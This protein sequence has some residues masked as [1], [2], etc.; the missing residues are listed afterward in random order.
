[1]KI[2]IRCDWGPGVGLGHVGR[3]IAIGE[4][5][6]AQGHEVT[7]F[8]GAGSPFPL[9]IST[10]VDVHVLDVVRPS[11]WNLET[12]PDPAARK[13]RD[14]EELDAVVFKSVVSVGIYDVL[15]LD[16]Y[17][18]GDYWLGLV[19][20]EFSAVH[21]L[22]DIDRRW[23]HA[24]T[25][26][27]P[28][29]GTLLDGETAQSVN[30]LRG[31]ELF[32]VSSSI[33]RARV[34][35]PMEH[36]DSTTITV[37]TGGADSSGLTRK[38]VKALSA[39]HDNVDKCVVIV[40]DSAPDREITLRECAAHNW[41]HISDE[42]ADVASLYAKSTL[43]LGAGG[44][45]ALDRCCLGV[46]QIV[47]SV[48]QNQVPQ[49]ERLSENGC[50]SYAGDAL[51]VTTSQLEMTILS[52]LKDSTARLR[53]SVAGRRAVD[54]YGAGRVALLLFGDF[55]HLESRPCTRDDLDLLYRWANDPDVRANALSREP[56]DWDTHTKW[57]N[58]MFNSSTTLIRIVEASGVPV[59]QLRLDFNDDVSTVTYSVDRHFRGRGIGTAAARMAVAEAMA[60]GNTRILAV[61]KASN[62]SSRRVF[63]AAGFK[64][65][66]DKDEEF[67]RFTLELQNRS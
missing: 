50:F 9:P 38:Y 29:P 16:H 23:T 63:D 56:I 60:L 66:S 35:T 8:A 62:A 52:L 51:S 33:A 61:V 41:I 26:I 42:I 24:R 17:F 48:T 40:G 21:V 53:Q 55:S 5:A 28:R 46:P 14:Y 1:M 47:C 65:S 19:S 10:E 2:A 12:N 27:D 39:L 67:V 4:A 11:W 43:V 18:L 49:C 45:S 32:P 30:R 13:F 7:I 15:L 3:C 64:F 31:L 6:T 25:V 34:M 20:K 58:R 44:V 59:G 22:D 37:F 54:T 57:F 36:R